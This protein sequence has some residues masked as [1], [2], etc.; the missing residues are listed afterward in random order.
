ML[1][2][3]VNFFSIFQSLGGFTSIEDLNLAPGVGTNL[4]EAN[5]QILTVSAPVQSSQTSVANRKANTRNRLVV[6][7]FQIMK[8]L[9]NGKLHLEAVIIQALNQLRAL[10]Q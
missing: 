3:N 10:H 8:Q 5:R 4:I 9:A 1:L 7:R 2:C 6:T